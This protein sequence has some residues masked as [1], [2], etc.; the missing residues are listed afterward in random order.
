MEDMLKQIL[1]EMQKMNSRMSNMENGMEE[2]FN[3]LETKVDG[4]EAGQKRIEEKIDNLTTEARSHFKQLQTKMDDHQ[5]AIVAV[6]D[7]LSGTNFKIKTLSGKYG[8]HT[9]EIES[10][11]RQIKS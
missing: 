6:G 4:L 1:E 9:I 5:R 2:S 3:R 11:I 10:L 8:E 7:E